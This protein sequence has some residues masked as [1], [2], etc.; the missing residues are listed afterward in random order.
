MFSL[1]Y[2]AFAATVFKGEIWLTGGRSDLYNMYNMQ[3]SFK[4]A[5]VWHS[6]DGSKLS[7]TCRLYICTDDDIHCDIHIGTWVQ[8]ALLYGDF[9]A[10]NKLVKQP[11]VIAPWYERF[12]HSMDALD[13]DGD[14]VT[15]IMLLAG[16]YSPEPSNDVWITP[17]GV[18]WFYCGLAPWSPRAWHSTTV[19]NNTLFI[20]GGSP[21]SNEVWRL[22]SVDIQ[23]RA[24]PLTR[25]A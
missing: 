18:T 2:I 3:F 10:Q 11:G 20:M 23:D 24:A 21:L 9:Y 22:D 6:N 14:G 17:D 5:D 19:Y 1:Y 12:A 13:L 15:D 16:G 25:A 8:E 4:N 7:F